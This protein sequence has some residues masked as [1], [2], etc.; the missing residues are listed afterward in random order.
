MTG[1]GG[2]QAPEA[3]GA[4]VYTLGAGGGM[5]LRA[6]DLLRNFE[7][8]DGDA[9]FITGLTTDSGELVDNGD[10]TWVFTPGADFNGNVQLT[11]EVSDGTE[12]VSSSGTIT[13]AHI[14]AGDARDDLLEG[15]TAMDAIAGGAGD[16]E[17]RGGAG[18]DLLEGGAGSD[19]LV[20]GEGTDTALFSGS[21]DEYEVTDNL[22]GS[23]TVTDTVDGRD[24]VDVITDIELLSFQ[25]AVYE[26]TGGDWTA[27]VEGGQEAAMA[28]QTSA[29]WTQAVAD[30]GDAAATSNALDMMPGGDLPDPS[31]DE[32][33]LDQGGGI[34]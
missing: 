29:D 2:N 1:A 24:G 22:D 7:D 13:V 16:D 5:E 33:P 12:V 31:P 23:F 26:N 27:V 32:D 21:R 19:V 4:V 10:G 18:D 6:E 9:L 3:T 14:V 25:D 17:L 20:G 15:G 11:M 8:R 34:I 28:G 30:G